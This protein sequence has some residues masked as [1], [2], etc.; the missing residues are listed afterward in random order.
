MLLIPFILRV[1]QPVT[2]TIVFASGIASFTLDSVTI[3]MTILFWMLFRLAYCKQPINKA[4]VGC[5]L[6]GG[7]G[8]ING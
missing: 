1:L 2:I 8:L 7:G 3:V 6:G 4:V 5:T